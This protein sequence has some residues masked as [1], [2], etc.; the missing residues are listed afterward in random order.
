MDS[1]KK[2][3][4]K[5]YKYEQDPHSWND[6]LITPFSDGHDFIWRSYDL[7]EKLI[8]Y[9]V[10]AEMSERPQT[11]GHSLFTI[12]SEYRGL[13][14]NYSA[15][16]AHNNIGLVLVDICGIFEYVKFNSCG[17]YMTIARKG[18]CKTAWDYKDGR[19]FC[20]IWDNYRFG[21]KNE[22]D[23]YVYD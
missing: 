21:R 15:F 2:L 7:D 10:K 13:N 11:I 3:E 12:M 17:P 8:P 23:E 18:V 1:L 4:I 19:N 9:L 16:Y 5:Y 22:K 14:S 6:L 20:A